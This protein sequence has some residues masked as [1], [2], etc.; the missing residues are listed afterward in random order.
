MFRLLYENNLRSK[1]SKIC[2]VCSLFVTSASKGIF[3]KIGKV[4]FN[5]YQYKIGY[6]RHVQT[7]I[8]F[9]DLSLQFVGIILARTPAPVT[10]TLFP[11]ILP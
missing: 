10:K 6:F 8:V 9:R 4:S 5:S 11:D 3:L 1:L 7:V 2:L